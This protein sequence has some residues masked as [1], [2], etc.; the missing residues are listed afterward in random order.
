MTR[1]TDRVGSWYSS[2]D[3]RTDLAQVA[4]A[5]LAV[6]ER[7]GRLLLIETSGQDG[8][9]RQRAFY[10]GLGYTLEARIRDFSITVTTR[11]SSGKPSRAA[12]AVYARPKAARTVLDPRRILRLRATH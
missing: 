11:S 1:P 12:S 4:A 7:G 3:G 9:D 2:P 10:A 5:E 8:F 6:R